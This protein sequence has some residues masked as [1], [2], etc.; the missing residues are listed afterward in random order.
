LGDATGVQIATVK[1]Q[2]ME[3]KTS[4]LIDN[5]A[6]GSPQK[7]APKH[8]FLRRGRISRRW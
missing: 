3:Q 8:T 1:L 2:E 4:T 5:R 6:E 7:I